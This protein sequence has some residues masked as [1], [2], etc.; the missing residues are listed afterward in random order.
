MGAVNLSSIEEVERLAARE[1]YLQSQAD[2][3]EQARGDLLQVIAEVDAAATE[4]FLTALAEVSAAFQELFEHFF[5]GGETSLE[6]TDPEQPL[7]S[8]VEVLVRLPG[9]RRQNLLLLSGGERAMT[10]LALLFALIK[11]RPTPF[12]VMDEIDAAIDAGN[13]ERLTEIIRE[14]AQRSQF[15]LITHNPRTME[16]A[17]V[18]YGVTM[19]QGGVSRLISVTLEDAKSVAKEPGPATTRVLPV[20]A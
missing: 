18:L 9:K 14:F 1:Q 15:I 6:L 19:R 4:A 17:Q 20:M 11:V 10:A 16:A 12:C 5:P 13:T 2:D 3:L 8:G 7:T